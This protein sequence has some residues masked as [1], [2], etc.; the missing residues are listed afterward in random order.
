MVYRNSA[1][2]YKTF[3]VDQGLADALRQTSHDLDATNPDLGP[4]AQRGGKLILYHGWN[5]P[6]ISAY[7]TIDY[8]NEVRSTMG[9][10]KADSFVRLF[11]VPGM[12]HCMG[13]PGADNFG[14]FGPAT[15]SGPDDAQHDIILALENWVENGSAPSQ[16]IAAHTTGEGA[17]RTITMTRPLCAWPRVA[18]YDGSGDPNQ[19]ASFRCVEGK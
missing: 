12:Q 4:F 15:V 17:A 2:D 8:F 16:L 18:R 1:W 3:N 10:D 11:M 9:A 5:D 19:S 7:G 14:Q 6:A 13:G